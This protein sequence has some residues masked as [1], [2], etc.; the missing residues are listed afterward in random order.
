M[1]RACIGL[2]LDRFILLHLVARLLCVFLSAFSN[3]V[4][5]FSIARGARGGCQ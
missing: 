1:A 2:R 5:L 3:S 4:I